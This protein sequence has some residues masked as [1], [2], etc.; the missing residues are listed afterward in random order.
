MDKDFYKV[1]FYYILFIFYLFI[2]FYFIYLFYFIIFC[3]YQKAFFLKLLIS[4]KMESF[5]V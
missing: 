3:K 1:F 5:S 2:Y 4:I